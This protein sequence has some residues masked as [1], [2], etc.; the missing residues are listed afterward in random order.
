MIG[1]WQYRCR[2]S[3]SCKG[4]KKRSRRH[5]FEGSAL[6]EAG[7]FGEVFFEVG[8]EARFGEEGVAGGEIF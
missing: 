8:S 7:V 2:S 6:E 3:G 1:T 5:F 4:A